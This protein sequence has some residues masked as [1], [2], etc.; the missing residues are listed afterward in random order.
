LPA[1]TGNPSAMP[2][3]SGARIGLPVDTA[4]DKRAAVA[5]L[6]RLGR[7]SIGN[8]VGRRAGA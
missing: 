7:K 4:A 6:S 3:D 8:I 2:R 1:S 5:P